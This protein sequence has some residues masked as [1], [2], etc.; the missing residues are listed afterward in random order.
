MY[1]CLITQFEYSRPQMFRTLD[2]IGHYPVDTYKQIKSPR[3]LLNCDLSS[4]YCYP[5]LEQLGPE[6]ITHGVTS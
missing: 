3:Y 1:P 5:P 6:Y 4:G 2:N